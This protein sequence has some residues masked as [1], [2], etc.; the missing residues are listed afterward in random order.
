[1]LLP[2][3]VGC[4]SH[5]VLDEPVDTQSDVY[6]YFLDEDEDGW[7]TGDAIMQVSGDTVTFFT[8]RNNRDC[9]DLSVEITG[10]I[11]SICPEDLVV[12]GATYAGAVYGGS[13]FVLVQDGTALVWPDYGVDACSPWGWGGALATFTAPDELTS[14]QELLAEVPVYAGY[15]GLSGDGAGGWQWDDGSGLDTGALHLSWCA[16]D[17]PDS[18]DVDA[19]ERLAL[20]KQADGA[21]CLGD[22]PDALVDEAWGSYDPPEYA[23]GQGYFICERD[24]PDAEPWDQY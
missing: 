5:W 12:G 8:A 24:V 17:A 11:G 3:L 23:M 21:W 1:L 20:I 9:D 19:S 16:G 4:Q 13:E 6:A 18:T 22:P 14:V 15:I 2:W 7:G 10:R